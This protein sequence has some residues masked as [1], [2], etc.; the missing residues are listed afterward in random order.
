MPTA[1]FA[2]SRL[3]TLGSVNSRRAP[4]AIHLVL[5]EGCVGIRSAT[6]RAAG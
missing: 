6:A 4:R 1:Y 5:G 3:T 2:C